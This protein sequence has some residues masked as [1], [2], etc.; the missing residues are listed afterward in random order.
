M[1]DARENKEVQIEARQFLGHVDIEMLY[2]GDLAYPEKSLVFERKEILDFAQSIVDGRVFRQ[3]KKMK[4]NYEHCYLI[5]IGNENELYTN[6]FNTVGENRFIGVIGELLAID[7]IKV[8]W[9]Q[10]RRQYWKLIMSVAKKIGT[11]E[12]EHRG[13]VTKKVGNNNIELSII[14]QVPGVGPKIGIDILAQFSLFEL[15]EAREKDL[16]Q[17]RGV[18]KVLSQEIKKVFRSNKNGSV[19]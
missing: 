13:F 4:S 17:I 14:C 6:R 15:F 16:Q 2:A 8:M 7:D 12:K 5:I 19:R 3:A 18:G 9:V 1:L 11:D 10:N